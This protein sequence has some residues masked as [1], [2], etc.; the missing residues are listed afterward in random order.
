MDVAYTARAEKDLALLPKIIQQR[1]AQKVR[2]IMQYGLPSGSFKHLS[3]YALHRVRI[4]DYRIVGTVSR[5]T[6]L[7]SLIRHR[8]DVYRELD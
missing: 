2:H 1:V 3:G 8:K 5:D 4:G 7:V 6:F